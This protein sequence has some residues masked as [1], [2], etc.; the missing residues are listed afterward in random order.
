MGEQGKGLGWRTSPSCLGGQ[1][2]R[3]VDPGSPG[4]GDRHRRAPQP[5]GEQVQVQ[6]LSPFFQKIQPVDRHHHGQPQL[7]QLGG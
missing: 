3:L 5:G 7:Q 6:R 2:C 1:L 4:G